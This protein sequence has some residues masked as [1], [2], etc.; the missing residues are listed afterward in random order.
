MVPRIRRGDPAPR[1]PCDRPPTNGRIQDSP[2]RKSF[3]KSLLAWYHKHKRDLPWRRTKDP[4]AIWLSEIMLQQTTV[5]TVIPYFERFLKKFPTLVDLAKGT[6]TDYLKLWQG[7]GLYNRIR[8]L[9]KAAQIIVEQYR[10]KIPSTKKEL[11]QLP[12]LGDYTAAAVASIA[13]GEKEAVVDGNVI[14]LLSRLF[15]YKEDIQK[16]ESRIFFQEKANKLL[17]ENRRGESCIRPGDHKAP[18]GRDRPYKIHPGDFNQAMME[19]GATICTSQ[20]PLCL[21]CPVRQFCQAFK[22]GTPEKFPVKNKKI[23]YKS[24]KYACLIY[25]RKNQIL[26]RQRKKNE[27]MSGLWE[28]PLKEIRKELDDAIGNMRPVS[29]T[30]MNRRM[31]IF[32]VFK[33]TNS[34]PPSL[35]KNVRWAS[36]EKLDHFPLST[37]TRK[38]IREWNLPGVSPLEEFQGK[39]PKKPEALRI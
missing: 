39:L 25:R 38:I 27:I 30:I 20:N 37:I 13:F 1:G 19:L 8:N 18:A 31:T 3:Q 11:I 16:K 24:Q 2:L 15:A 32:P 9:H 17:S 29:H 7:L 12:G 21:L 23:T 5:K 35:R 26:L 14:R 28:F 6:E 10:G 36:L 4:Y 33:K 34:L 22:K